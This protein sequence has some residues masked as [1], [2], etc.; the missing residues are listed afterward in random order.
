MLN[1]CKKNSSEATVVY[2]PLDS[3]DYYE[4]SEYTIQINYEKDCIEVYDKLKEETYLLEQDPF[5]LAD[6]SMGKNWSVKEKDKI[7]GIFLWKNLLYF[8]TMP[9]EMAINWGYCVYQVNLDTMEKDLIYSNISGNDN[10]YYGLNVS[11]VNEDVVRNRTYIRYFFVCDS[12][13]FFLEGNNIKQVNLCSGQEQTLVKQVK[14]E[15][16]FCSVYPFIYYLD[17]SNCI[18]EYNV[19]TM[20]KQSKHIYAS[21]LFI[22]NG[23]LNYIPIF[24]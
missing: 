20:E 10:N 16:G 13:L 19:N 15:T 21:E 1:G 18:W 24:E 6:I 22:Q 17:E 2:S 9:S 23:E 14:E 12:Y 7:E 5:Y 11:Y 3:M 4:N 8:I